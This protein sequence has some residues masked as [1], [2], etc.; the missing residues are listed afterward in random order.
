MRTWIG[1]PLSGWSVEIEVADGL[2]HAQRPLRSR[3]EDD[4]DMSLA[5]MWV[6]LGVG[7]A[8]VATGGVLLWLD[9]APTSGGNR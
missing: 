9:E 5:R 2:T 8:L 6:S 1:A 3:L 4:Y 7:T